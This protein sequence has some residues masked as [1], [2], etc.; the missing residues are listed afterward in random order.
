MKVDSVLIF[1][2]LFFSLVWLVLKDV[3]SSGLLWIAVFRYVPVLLLYAKY[4]KWS[5]RAFLPLLFPIYLLILSLLGDSSY[6]I[7]GL[8]VVAMVP[9]YLYVF[10]FITFSPREI[11]LL[12]I[13]VLFAYLSYVV[14]GLIYRRIINP[15]QIAF[16]Y[17]VL[18]LLLFFCVYT[19]MSGKNAMTKL[20]IVVLAIFTAILI[21]F[22]RSRNS[23]LVFLLLPIAFVLRNKVEKFQIVLLWMLFVLFFLYP[24]VYTQLAYNFSFRSGQ[25]TV[26][27]D[28]DVFSGR[29][30]IWSYVFSELRNPSYFYFGGIDTEWWGKSLHNSALDIV[31]RYGVPSMLVLALIIILY[32]KKM[33]GL[34]NNK[35]KSLLLLVL[36]LM[37]WGLN[38][39]GL[40]LGYSYFVFLPYCIIHSKNV[41]SNLDVT[42]SNK[43]S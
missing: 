1:V 35:H 25:E 28:Q 32:F 17:M 37:I 2:S 29:E 34:I 16:T 26:F 18:S 12:Q 19:N 9:I 7:Q 42:Q 10:S 11:S 14:V 33:C 24:W 20:L 13:L 3:A 27:M 36:T 41:R 31:V 38:E 8:L 39:S 30:I 6:S 21:L 22:T 23:L 15:N 43:L 4:F 40:F 5:F